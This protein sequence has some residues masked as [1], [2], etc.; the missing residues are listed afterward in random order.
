M[1]VLSCT[2]S[3]AGERSPFRSRQVDEY[4]V[5]STIRPRTVCL[6]FSYDVEALPSLE[7]YEDL[8]AI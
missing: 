1:P 4:A 8:R 6:R 2:R 7:P 3:V 5:T